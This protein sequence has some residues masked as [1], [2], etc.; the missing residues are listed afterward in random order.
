[1]APSAQQLE[2]VAGAGA[3]D[4]EFALVQRELDNESHLS[5]EQQPL[6][7]TDRE[8]DDLD[9]S[10]DG[11][12]GPPLSQ[13]SLVSIRQTIKRSRGES[14]KSSAADRLG[15]ELLSIGQSLLATPSPV[16]PSDDI[17]QFCNSVASSIRGFPSRQLQLM[18][19]VEIQKIVA[20]LELRALAL[21]S[22]WPASQLHSSPVHSFPHGSP[23]PSTSFI[24]L[25][26]ATPGPNVILPPFN[27]FDQ[28]QM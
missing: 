6:L 26:P 8:S 15:A 14:R 1:M 22:S 11:A 2:D 17:Q 28:L 5:M 27:S 10:S 16:E 25:A 24:S 18:A 21:Q 9:K 4:F 23:Q 3:S 12:N 13:K 20:D 7:E 19:K